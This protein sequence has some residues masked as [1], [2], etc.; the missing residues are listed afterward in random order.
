MESTL[1]HKLDSL[2]EKL[3]DY[4]GCDSKTLVIR[5]T[6][7]IATLMGFFATL[8]LTLAFIL[9]APGLTILITYGYVM[10]CCHYY[11][12]RCLFRIGPARN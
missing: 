9:F 12:P 7:W 4:P 8:F 5:K 2:I 1:F 3:H 6:L 11:L 10:L